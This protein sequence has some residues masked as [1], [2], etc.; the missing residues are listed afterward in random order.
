[1]MYGLNVS[2]SVVQ[3]TPDFPCIN[4]LFAD[5]SRKTIDLS[6][7]IFKE[8]PGVFLPLRD[9]DFFDQVGVVNGAVTWP[10]EADLAP[11]AMYDDT[12]LSQL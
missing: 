10:N 9:K 2:W 4:V 11:D 3:V 8:D 12:F 5:G 7:I 6:S 1:M